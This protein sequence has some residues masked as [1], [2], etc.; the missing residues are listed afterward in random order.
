MKITVYYCKITN[1]AFPGKKF[2]LLFYYL[3]NNMAV[4]AQ[5]RYK[6]D[7]V[8]YVV[9]VFYK[10]DA[11]YL[12]GA[13]KNNFMH[14]PIA[15]IIHWEVM[16]YLKQRGISHYQVGVQQFGPLV[17]DQPSTKHI[18]ISRFKRGFGGVTLPY[19]I[20]EKFY[21]R[22]YCKKLWESRIQNYLNCVE[23]I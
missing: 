8:G 14:C 15:H 5:A 17:Y 4:M 11:Y 2:R 19:F 20:G 12:M 9:V 21:S 23:E 13:N 10:N 18:S 3:K 16:K 6:G 1:M 7:A 22:T